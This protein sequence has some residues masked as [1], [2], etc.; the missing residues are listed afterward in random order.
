[1]ESLHYLLMKTH[2]ILN[3]E[4]LAGAAELGLS[5]GQPKVLEFLREYGE[6]NQKTIACHCEIEQAT[7]GSILLRMEQSGLISRRQRAGN[8]RSLYVSL[9]PEGQ[10]AAEKME[11]VF[12]KADARA[13]SGL[14]EQETRQLKRLLERVCAA[15][16][17]SEPSEKEGNRNE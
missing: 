10:K 1:M 15:V 16:A 8:R 14:S 6:S 7:V 9:T 3:R 11:N 13:E 5:S 12:R 4:I 17:G 2:T